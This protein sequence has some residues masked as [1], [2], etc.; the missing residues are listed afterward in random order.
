MFENFF[1][2]F[3]PVFVA[4]DAIGLLPIFVSFVEGVEKKER[5]RVIFQAM[6]T[7]V[8]LAVG[9]IFLGKWIFRVLGIGIGDFAIAG[10]VLLFTI[11]ITDIMS[12]EKKR[13]IPSDGLGAV[14]LGTPLMVGPAVL[15]T[16]MLIVGQYGVP[17]TL[18][19]VVLNVLIAGAIFFMADVLIRIVGNAGV[20]ALSKIMSLLLAAIAVM[21]I[22]KGV[23]LVIAMMQ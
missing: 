14:P 7:A 1:L 16:C 13:R 19:S 12:S 15:T 4:V 23:F 20:K 17:A 2:A 11:A 8:L 22:R 5:A 10:G 6:I 3:I 9:F 18:F 21:M